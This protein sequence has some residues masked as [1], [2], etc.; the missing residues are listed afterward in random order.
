[1]ATTATVEVDVANE[2]GRPLDD[3]LA[4]MSRSR[5]YV[6]IDT[7]R[8]SCCDSEEVWLDDQGYYGCSHCGTE[9]RRVIQ[10]E[11][12]DP[13][14]PGGGWPTV[15]FRGPRW[16]LESMLERHGYDDG[17]DAYVTAEVTR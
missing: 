2:D 7:D 4:D 17:W 6:D 14:G 15:E 11:I 8:T 1:M 9:T 10:Y 5:S 12:L 3:V 13:H 16:A